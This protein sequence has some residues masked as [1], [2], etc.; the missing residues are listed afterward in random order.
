MS[1]NLG[2]VRFKTAKK[3]TCRLEYDAT[4]IAYVL[5]R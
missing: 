3:N 5:P 1:E 4:I 2:S